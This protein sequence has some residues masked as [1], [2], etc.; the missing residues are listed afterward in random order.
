MLKPGEQYTVLPPSVHTAE[1]RRTSRSQAGG[2][3]SD[4][5][6]ATLRW[7]GG[8]GAWEGEGWVRGARTMTAVTRA[9]RR[10]EAARGA[11]A[12]AARRCT[13]PR[14][15]TRGVQAARACRRL[16]MMRAVRCGRGGRGRGGVCQQPGSELE[17]SRSAAATPRCQ[18]S[19]LTP[20]SHCLSGWC[21]C[22]MCEPMR[23]WACTCVAKPPPACCL[24]QQPHHRLPGACWHAQCTVPV[25]SYTASPPPHSR[26]WSQ[27]VHAEHLDPKLLYT[28]CM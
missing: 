25:M 23:Y 19:S 7:P 10:S 4:S 21:R 28:G 2:N 18:L 16:L 15:E 26:A 9:V 1:A 22:S 3:T 5:F 12:R 24:S 8:C 6:S 14:S 11:A 17:H 20:P 27:Q 13:A